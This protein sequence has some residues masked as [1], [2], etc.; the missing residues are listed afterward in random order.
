MAAAPAA[1]T[2]AAAGTAVQL[3]RLVAQGNPTI[4]FLALNGAVAPEV[5]N[6][7]AAQQ[8]RGAFSTAYYTSLQSNARRLRGERVRGPLPR[9][10][11]VA[12]GRGGEPECVRDHEGA[13]LPDLPGPHLRRE[14]K[15]LSVLWRCA[16]PDVARIRDRGAVYRNATCGA[17]DVA[18]ALGSRSGHGAP[19]GTDALEPQST[20]TAVAESTTG[21]ACTSS[22]TVSRGTSKRSDQT[23]AFE[24]KGEGATLGAEYGLPGGV[25]GVAG[26]YSKPRVRFGNDSARVRQP[27]LADR[28]LWQH[29]SRRLLRPGLS[30][31][32]QGQ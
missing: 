29:G 21:C 12:A 2:A 16:A 31:L 10:A 28:R 23:A 7:P 15:R 4:S 14:L 11:A 20:F 18:G 32:R 19:M 26:N 5:A 13:G 27:Q 9:R 8:I 30:R 24:V 3:D 22:A 25:V 6:N 17:A 1:G